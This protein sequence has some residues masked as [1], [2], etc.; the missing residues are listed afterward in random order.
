MG[1]ALG[2]HNLIIRSLKMFRFLL[3]NLAIIFASSAVSAQETDR[4]VDK[5]PVLADTIH[6]THN[7]ERLGRSFEIFIKTS[8]QAGEQER[9]P[10]IY[11]LDA[12]Q[13]F[14]L[15]TS[16]SWALTLAEEMQPS[17]IVGIGYGAENFPP[18]M[19]GT[20]YTAP[21]DR[22]HYGGADA[23]TEVLK[24]E[25]FPRVE[26]I[27]RADPE[28]RILMG[29]SLG[30]QFVLHAALNQPGLVDLG[31]AINPA[32]HRNLPLFLEMLS[33]TQAGSHQQ[34]LYVSSAD[35]DDDR[36]R[37]PAI[38]FIAA[39]SQRDDLPWCLRID[40]LEDHGHLTSMPRSFRNALRWYAR[41]K[42][43]C[44]AIDDR[45]LRDASE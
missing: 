1:L 20:D 27:T 2:W 33:Q 21:G 44:G 6:I 26:A 39:A 14:P 5:I 16:Y 45:L 34:H 28:R 31:I 11:V 36:F 17:I 10:I 38:E 43:A 42:P 18:N 40:Q 12:D 29:Q 32:L 19:R 24:E 7:S 3:F 23:F 37:L 35:G 25:I 4:V 30:G 41:D 9:L 22:P 8:D 13:S 15:I